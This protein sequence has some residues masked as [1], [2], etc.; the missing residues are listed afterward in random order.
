VNFRL[1]KGHT[2]TWLARFG[3]VIDRVNS[4]AESCK[5]TT[6]VLIRAREMA[7]LGAV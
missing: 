6:I 2:S 7:V 4:T 5:E 3:Q 1:L